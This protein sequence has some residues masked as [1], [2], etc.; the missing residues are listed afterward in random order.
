M[1]ERGILPGSVDGMRAPKGQTASLDWEQSESRSLRE[2]NF[3]IRK[4]EA[5]SPVYNMNERSL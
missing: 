5:E 1:R 2:S 3:A 4:L